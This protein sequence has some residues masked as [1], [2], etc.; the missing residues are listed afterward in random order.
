MKQQ[1]IRIPNWNHYSL[2]TL[3]FFL[4]SLCACSE[5]KAVAQEL[6][7][8]K[9]EIFTIVEEKPSYE[10]GI[11]TFYRYLM[12]EI[13]YPSEARNNGVEGHVFLGFSIERDGSVSNVRT[14]RDIGAGCG[15]EAERVM[16]TVTTFK[17]GSQRGRS[18]KTEMI[19]PFKFTL[20]PTKTNADNSP[21]GSIAIGELKIREEQFQLDVKYNEG[22]WHG[23]LKNNNGKPLPG[24]NIIL[25]GTKYGR[26]TDLDGK[27][28][29]LAKASQNV[30]IS[31]VGFESI[32][33]TEK[34]SVKE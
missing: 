34:D 27:F 14:I 24:A 5:N 26:V 4:A 15:N 19:L 33:L 6:N 1:T 30:I 11:D 13:R 22:A 9:R 2:F 23:T 31:Y 10:G 7:S 18:V 12:N 16:K 21:Q 20:D 32:S 8:S 29:I 17:P 3:T 25:E 28:S